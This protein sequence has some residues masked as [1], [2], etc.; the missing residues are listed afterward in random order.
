LDQVVPQA[1][2]IDRRTAEFLRR[3]LARSR[4]LQEVTSENRSRVQALFEELNRRFAGQRPS[5][6]EAA[7]AVEA[8]QG[9]AFPSFRLL[10]ASLLGGLESLY[11]PRLRKTSAEIEPLDNEASLAEGDG[12]LRRLNQALQGSLTVSR[13][14]RFVA[15][16]PTELGNRIDSDRL[17]LRNEEDLEDWIACLLHGSSAGASFRVEVPRAVADVDAPEFVQKLAYRL[18]RFTLIRK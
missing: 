4:Y 11:T 13:A 3:S 7:L 17:P 14:N 10:E 18:E 5:E 6:V 8:D 9:H 2:A 15:A 1:E 12:V 16:L